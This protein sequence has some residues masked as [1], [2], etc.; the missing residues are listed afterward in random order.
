PLGDRQSVRQLRDL[1]VASPSTRSVVPLRQIAEVGPAWEFGEIGRRNGV[2]TLTVRLDIVL[3]GL[4]NN[5]LAQLQPEIAK[6]KLPPGHQAR[7]TELDD[8]AAEHLRRFV[9][10]AGAGV[11]VRLHVLPRAAELVRHRGAQWHHPHRLCGRRGPERARRGHPRRRTPHAAHLPDFGR[12]RC[13]RDSDDTQRFRFVG[14]PRVGYL[15]WPTLLNGAHAVCPA[16]AVLAVFPQGRRAEAAGA[17]G[18]SRSAGGVRIFQ[19]NL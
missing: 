13:G 10:A 3:G 16:G 1:S 15:L 19:K 17:A 4:A 14:S 7:A 9:W 2:R 8:L 11:S 18:A 12:R 5:I 6:I